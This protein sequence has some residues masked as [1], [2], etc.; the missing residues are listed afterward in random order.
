MS[1][2]VPTGARPEWPHDPEGNQGQTGQ[3]RVPGSG[4]GDRRGV[5]PGSRGNGQA[6][7]PQASNPQG[8]NPQGVW[9]PGSGTPGS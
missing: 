5:P 7:N 8:D 2:T 4:H 9:R 6:Y 3:Q 1:R